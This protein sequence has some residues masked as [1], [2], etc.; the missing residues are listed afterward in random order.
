[1]P[2]MSWLFTLRHKRNKYCGKS[3]LLKPKHFVVF[4][5]FTL[6]P[7]GKIAESAFSYCVEAW[8]PLPSV[9]FIDEISLDLVRD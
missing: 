4:P 7:I 6:F 2:Q 8:N 5:L 3:I 9:D 1:M